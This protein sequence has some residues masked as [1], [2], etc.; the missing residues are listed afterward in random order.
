[1]LTL[2]QIS[3]QKRALIRRIEARIAPHLWESGYRTGPIDNSRPL[4]LW[5]SYKRAGDNERAWFRL[6][7][8][9]IDVCEGVCED[10]MITSSEGGGLAT[11]A[12]SDLPLE[13]LLRVE[14]WAN[15]QF[16]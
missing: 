4:K 1:M 3:T 11:M 9:T 10:G 16:A 14:R 5:V 15:K 6:N 8:L 13:D 7:G 12:F 2:R